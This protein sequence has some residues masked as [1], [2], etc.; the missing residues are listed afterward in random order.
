ML[1]NSMLI[2]SMSISSLLM[3]HADTT[4]LERAESGNQFFQMLQTGH[5]LHHSLLWQV[6]TPRGSI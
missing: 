3:S 1:I 6:R 5:D 2:N 4:G